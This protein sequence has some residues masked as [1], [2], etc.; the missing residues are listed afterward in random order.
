MKVEHMFT[1]KQDVDH[2]F[3]REKALSEGI[4]EVAAE[5]RLIDVADLITY[6][7]SGQLA[8]IGDLINSSAE[9]VFKHGTLTYG[10]AADTDVKWGNPPEIFLDMEFRHMSVWVCFS[11]GL[12]ALHGSVGIHSITFDQPSENPR[13]N[14]DRLVAA[15]ADAR[16]IKHVDDLGPQRYRA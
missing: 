11:L 2:L 12:G 15:L 3:V 7:R 8:N 4:K 1:Q 6:I 14:T 9:L 13:E 16:L 5:L 10:W